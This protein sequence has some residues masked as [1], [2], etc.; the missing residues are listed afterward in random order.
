[1][2]TVI[3]AAVGEKFQG[4]PAPNKPDDVREIQT[5][6]AKALGDTCPALKDGVCDAAMKT[7]IAEFQKKWGTVPDSTVDP[8]GH[9]LKNL[10]R[11][12]SPIQ[13]SHI[14]LESVVTV[15]TDGKNMNSRGGYRIQAR[16]SDG[17]PLPPK[18]S[19]YQ[20][21]LIVQNDRN[22]L[23]LTGGSLHDLLAKDNLGDLLNIIDDLGLW[24]KPV[25]CRIQLRYKGSMISTSTVPKNLQA[26][27][28]PHNGVLVPLDETNNGDV[29]TYQG[30]P[31]AKDFHG[32][33]FLQVAGYSKFLFV[34]GGLL[35]TKDE[36]RG[37][38]CIT[39]AGTACGAS[40]QHMAAAPDLAQSLGAQTCSVQR[41]TKD[42]KTGKEVA[43]TVSLKNA[44]PADV[45]AFLTNDTPGSFLMW[46]GGHVVLVVEGKVNEFAHSKGGYAQSDVEDWLEPYK[47][48]KLTVR[49]LASAPARAG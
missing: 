43:K 26:P 30:D 46:S 49:R 25:P 44:D 31:D 13:I 17:G 16:T 10:N 32:R 33:M 36:F 27:I 20:L 1:M 4:K 28:E 42:P 24:T 47:T 19:G 5:L 11:L 39:Y 23:E 6:L 18:G 8:F 35:E 2:A 7:A 12:A 37:F 9:T 14:N 15:Y 29:L 45:K 38:D 41:K 22:S 34:Y 3:T 48:M 40:N 21:H